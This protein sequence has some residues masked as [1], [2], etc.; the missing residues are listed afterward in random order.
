MKMAIAIGVI[1]ILL[2]I[3]TPILI[4]AFV[5]TD[6]LQKA[7]HL[8]TIVTSVFACGLLVVITAL[9]AAILILVSVLTNLVNTKVG[10]L[11]DKVNETADTARGTAAYIGEGVVSPLVKVS[12]ILA[13]IRAAIRALFRGR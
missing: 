8:A 6:A 2:L 7:A 12:G 5:P 13:A 11:I 4:F 3:A 9:V 10:P 1:V